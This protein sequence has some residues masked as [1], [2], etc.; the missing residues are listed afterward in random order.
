MLQ[1]HSSVESGESR[2]A[3]RLRAI[4]D[5]AY[6][7]M[8]DFRK[9]SPS[10]LFVQPWKRAEELVCS[11]LAVVLTDF[12]WSWRVFCPCNCPDQH[13]MVVACVDAQCMFCDGSSVVYC[14][15]RVSVSVVC[16]A[17]AIALTMAVRPSGR[18]CWRALMHY[19]CMYR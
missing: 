18:R 10:M 7:E 16:S 6:A 19:R 1:E 11:A 12:A 5:T 14:A 4:L 15:M 17:L 2:H 3:V 13:R 8:D 9:R